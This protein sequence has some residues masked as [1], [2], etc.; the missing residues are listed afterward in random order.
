MW[1]HLKTHKTIHDE[2]LK[3]ALN[4]RENERKKEYVSV[5]TGVKKSD[6]GETN[7]SRDPQRSIV[8]MQFTTD[9][10]VNQK[11]SEFLIER[12]VSFNTIDNQEF[13]DFLIAARG[14]KRA[15]TL[16]RE[17]FN[18]NLDSYHSLFVE[19]VGVLIAEASRGMYGFKFINLMHDLWTNPSVQSVLGASISFID[20]NWKKSLRSFAL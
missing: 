20:E 4:K 7:T 6:K 1:K 5:E 9:K 2:E 16:T 17:N 14:N 3:A 13:R 18:N 19:N 12:G 8:G 15:K 11:L 10:Y